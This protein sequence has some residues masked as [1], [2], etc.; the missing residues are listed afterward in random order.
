MKI[1]VC[2]KQV[3]AT[4]RVKLDP[5]TKTIIREGIE[6]E[7]NPY[8]FHAVE[9]ALRL[10]EKLGC[11]VT[12]VSMGIPRVAEMLRDVLA[13][14]ADEAILLSDRRF[15]GSDT[16]ATAHA[17]AGAIRRIGGYQL[18]ICGKQATDGDT[19]Q[20][21]PALAEMLSI[22]HT[23]YVSE[24]ENIGKVKA[25]C[26]KLTDNGYERI[27]LDL[28]ALITVV[29]EINTP[30]LPSLAGCRRA[31]NMEANIWSADDIKVE[32]SCLG[33]DGSPTHVIKIF[34]PQHEARTEFI[35]GS[36]GEQAREL[37]R[38]LFDMAE[39]DA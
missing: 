7:L 34:V 11:Q 8:D 27:R 12:V 15:A 23:T 10:K 19:A 4:T 3:P 36:A 33:L 2:V 31:L 21:G 14:G 39:K 1:I 20:V 38:R 13:L 22:P 5:E 35:Q 9:E 32:E 17:L 30:R 24:I 16:L 25:V 28:P 37:A 18:V 26:R 6:N 29:R